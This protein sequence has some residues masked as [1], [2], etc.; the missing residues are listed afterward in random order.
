MIL[1]TTR[2]VR[3]YFGRPI[4]GPHT[5]TEKL[6]ADCL[7]LEEEVFRLRRIVAWQKNRVERISTFLEP[8]VKC[9]AHTRWPSEMPEDWNR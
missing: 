1:H 4:D 2:A 7:A 5:T 8:D 3:E 9:S 6:A